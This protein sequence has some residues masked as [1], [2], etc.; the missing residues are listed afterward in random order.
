MLCALPC[1]PGFAQPVLNDDQLA[2]VGID[3]LGVPGGALFRLVI[4]LRGGAKVDA[5]AVLGSVPLRGGTI[6]I[7]IYMLGVLVQY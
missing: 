1:D 3:H 4:R 2:E 6:Y 5:R 7:Y